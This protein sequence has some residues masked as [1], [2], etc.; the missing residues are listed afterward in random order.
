MLELPKPTKN[1]KKER[2]KAPLKRKN[3][4]GGD[5]ER[6]GKRELNKRR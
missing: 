2:R 3:V 1:M 6:L 5:A 4:G